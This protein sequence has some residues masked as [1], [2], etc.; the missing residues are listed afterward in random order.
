MNSA[1][2]KMRHNRSHRNFSETEKRN[3]R[4]FQQVKKKY[5]L[6]QLQ[7]MIWYTEILLTVSTITK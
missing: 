1:Q 6:Q 5:C 4:N 2:E 7:Q 3:Q